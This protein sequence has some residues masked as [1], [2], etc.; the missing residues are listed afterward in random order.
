M[1]LRLMGQDIFNSKS[2]RDYTGSTLLYILPYFS[3]GKRYSMEA[4]AFFKP[5]RKSLTKEQK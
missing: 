5:L 2:S 4:F 3:P 1:D